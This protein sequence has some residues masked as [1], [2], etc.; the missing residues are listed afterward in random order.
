MS[1]TEW[2]ETPKMWR[3]RASL[4]NCTMS[5]ATMDFILFPFFQHLAD[6]AA[7]RFEVGIGG[8]VE[9]GVLGAGDDARVLGD[10][11]FRDVDAQRISSGLDELLK[12]DLSLARQQPIEE[13][14]G[15]VWMGR[16]IDEHDV[17]PAGSHEPSL[18]EPVGSKGVDRKPLALSVPDVEPVRVLQRGDRVLSLRYPVHHLPD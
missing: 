13:N 12:C 8:I 4:K 17:P 5:R 18:F 9:Q 15:G 10:V 7:H 3:T 6:E 16:G 11:V 2:P 1:K 14:P